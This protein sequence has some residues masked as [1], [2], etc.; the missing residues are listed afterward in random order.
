MHLL[1]FLSI[2]F[3]SFFVKQGGHLNHHGQ[4]HNVR[5]RR[6]HSVADAMDGLPNDSVSLKHRVQITFVDEHGNQEGKSSKESRGA[7]CS[8]LV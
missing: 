1:L 8:L 4:G 2:F 3:S 5:I 7:N 6:T